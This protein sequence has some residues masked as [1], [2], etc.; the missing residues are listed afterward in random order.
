MA[1]TRDQQR[2]RHAFDRVAVVKAGDRDEYK[3]AVN[4]FGA[5]VIRSGLAAALAFLERKKDASS[6]FLNDLRSAGIPGVTKERSL[7]DQIRDMDVQS[8]ML[9]TREILKVTLWFKRA[10]QAQF[11][12]NS[13]GNAHA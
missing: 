11:K 3:I 2:A 12:E 7:P 5:N 9:V 13:G 6:L 10:V 8:Y 1:I 4:S